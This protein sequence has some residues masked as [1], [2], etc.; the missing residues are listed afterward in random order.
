MQC[1]CRPAT[2][3]PWVGGANCYWGGNDGSLWWLKCRPD[4][5]LHQLS[6]A[7]SLPM[8]A[9]GAGGHDLVASFGRMLLRVQLQTH[10]C[11]TLE[12]P[13]YCTS[14]PWVGPEDALAVSQEG[15]L[16]LLSLGSQT[17]QVESTDKVPSPFSGSL[18]PPFWNGREW[19][20]FDQDGRLFIGE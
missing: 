16:Y 10:R 1:P 4:L 8:L 12:L 18:L 11:D 13:Q 6:G 9:L 7:Q 20:I 2:L 19:L 14:S 17:F 3:A 5:Q 15:Q